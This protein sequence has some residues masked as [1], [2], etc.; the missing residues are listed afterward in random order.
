MQS[1]SGL[2]VMKTRPADFGCGSPTILLVEDEAFVREVTCEILRASGYEVL[3]ARS[4]VE[5]EKIYEERG[6]EVSLVITDIVLPAETGIALAAA[7]RQQNKDL[8]VIFVTGYSE[9]ARKISKQELLAKPFS[10]SIL[11]GRVRRL[12]NDAEFELPQEVG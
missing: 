2:R 12:L 11:L 5:A 3:S 8:K 9:Q 10:A 7:L 6:S 1:L 4:A